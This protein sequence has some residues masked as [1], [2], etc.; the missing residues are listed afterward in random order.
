LLRFSD[1]KNKLKRQLGFTLLELL[2]VIGI[3]AVGSGFIYPEIGKWKTKR[4]IEQDFHTIISTIGYLKTKTR[5]INGTAEL[6]CR[7]STIG[8]GE[9]TLKY[10]VS[11]KR[12]SDG[13]FD[14]TPDFILNIVE[15]SGDSTTYN[16]LTGKVNVECSH[17]HT[18]FNAGGSAGERGSGD[19]L[20]IKVN[21][22]AGGVVDLVNYNAYMI[23][24]STATAYIQRYKWDKS[25]DDY[26]ELN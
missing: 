22:S 19:M 2:V 24:V 10:F 16:I 12:N 23:R 9:P 15:Q 8:G 6:D 3:L 21:Y 1:K 20:E 13:S 25:L 18:I 5:T 11:S 14:K 17:I 7:N 4:N 26:R